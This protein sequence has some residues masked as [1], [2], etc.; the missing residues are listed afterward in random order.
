MDAKH[1]KHQM[2]KFRVTDCTAQSTLQEARSFEELRINL[3]MQRG[4][5]SPSIMLLRPWDAQILE[6]GD[7]VLELFSCMT[8]PYEVRLV[9]VQESVAAY[10]PGTWGRLMESHARY[11]D[12][13]SFAQH[14]EIL[15][16]QLGDSRFQLRMRE[17]VKWVVNSCAPSGL[18]SASSSDSLTA[19]QQAEAPGVAP[20]N[21]K[22]NMATNN[23]HAA[24]LCSSSSFEARFETLIFV[25]QCTHE[26]DLNARGDHQYTLLHVCAEAGLLA[27]VQTLLRMQNGPQPLRHGHAGGVAAGIPGPAKDNQSMWPSLSSP[28]AMMPVIIANNNNNDENDGEKWEKRESNNVPTSSVPWK[29]ID[30]NAR[31]EYGG[32]PFY[33]AVIKGHE[34]IVRALL[35]A[36]ADPHIGII[37]NGWSPLHFAANEGH[38]NVVQL[39][40]TSGRGVDVNV[41]STKGD[42]PLHLAYSKGRDE[43]V[44]ILLRHGADVKAKNNKGRKYDRHDSEFT[45]G[46]KKIF[47]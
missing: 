45:K 27:A 22:Y 13:D 46:L 1:S 5:L 38:A 39:L 29:R 14:V 35:T 33:K 8:Q 7:N 42:T 43:V 15:R 12:R 6:D 44:Q 18:S 36:G 23:P 9:N 17:W 11:G 26:V 24:S 21:N 31:D 41:R 16:G 37:F 47:G 2:I 32:T 10:D 28:W 34:E 40:L 30:V 19:P 25:A 3:A 4:V 20:P